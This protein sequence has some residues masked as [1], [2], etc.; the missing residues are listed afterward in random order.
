MILSNMDYDE[1]QSKVG[2]RQYFYI[3]LLNFK[4]ILPT[5][6]IFIT[7]NTNNEKWDAGFLKKGEKNR[8]FYGF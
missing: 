1:K 2:G 3:L 7:N 4:P 6:L 8:Y 5:D